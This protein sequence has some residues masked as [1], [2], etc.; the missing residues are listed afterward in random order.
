VR[1]VVSALGL[2]L[3]APAL[4]R[5]HRLD[6]YLQA[7]RVAVASERVTI[8][9]SLTPGANL[10]NAIIARLDRDGDGACSPHEAE[11]YGREILAA[12]SASVDTRPLALSLRRVDVPP[13]AEF[14]D[15]VGTIRVEV[16][17]DTPVALTGAHVFRFE[18]RYQLGE[19]IYLANALL[20]DEAS[21]T[22]RRQLRDSN[23]Q[24][25]DV[26][27][28]VAPTAQT[29][30]AWLVVAAIVVVAHARFRVRPPST[31]SRLP[32]ALLGTGTTSPERVAEAR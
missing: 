26:H 17:A 23:Q 8:E 6:E 12:L 24:V 27:Y 16:D 4:A 1:L 15:G 11:Q 5:A 3:L 21:I 14:H 7:A 10:A 19:S 13:V 20:P 2:V 31:V 32:S 18:N 29:G 30:L 28:D 9:L 25:L 22:I